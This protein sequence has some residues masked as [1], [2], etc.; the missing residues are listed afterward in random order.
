MFELDLFDIQGNILRGYRS[1]HFARFLFFAIRESKFSHRVFRQFIGDLLKPPGVTPGQWQSPPTVTT[2]IAFTYRGLL[3]LRLQAECLASF[4]PEFQEGMKRR[5]LQLGD[6]GPSDPRTG[7]NHG[8]RTPST[9]SCRV[10]R[11]TRRS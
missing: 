9:F 11:Q 8:A 5:F 1:F 2:N 6:T 7:M 4:P 3:A 10:M